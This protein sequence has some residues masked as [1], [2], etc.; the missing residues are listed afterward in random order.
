MFHNPWFE[1]ILQITENTH[2]IQRWA[3]SEIKLDTFSITD[4]GLKVIL[5][6]YIYW[7]RRTLYPYTSTA[8]IFANNMG[9]HASEYNARKKI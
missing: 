5:K 9:M 4:N 1:Y 8:L 6:I 7:S 2:Y 3:K